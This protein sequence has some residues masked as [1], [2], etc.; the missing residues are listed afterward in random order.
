MPTMTRTSR[1]VFC[2][3]LLLATV[4]FLVYCPS[5]TARTNIQKATVASMLLTRKLIR[6]ALVDLHHDEI[7]TQDKCLTLEAIRHLIY[8]RFNFDN[9]IDYT[10]C[11]LKKA[12]NEVGPLVSKILQGNRT[13]IYLRVK[14][15]Q[16]SRITFILLSCSM[17]IQ[18]EEPTKGKAWTQA[19]EL[20]EAI[21]ESVSE[22]VQIKTFRDRSAS[23]T[24]SQTDLSI[25]HYY[26]RRFPSSHKKL[27]AERFCQL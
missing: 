2:I 20:S 16:K 5:P 21:V 18:P 24:L 10:V 1:P 25:A 17:D 4:A 11:E 3:N 19:L 22:T 7:T 9:G 27:V 23:K 15:T 13:G 6:S 14:H 26:A 8:T 12:V